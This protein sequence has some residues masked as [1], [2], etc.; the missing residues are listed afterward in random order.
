VWG[1]E[2]SNGSEFML[3][4]DPPSGWQCGFPREYKPR[5]GESV[6]DTLR[7]D[8]Y[9]EKLDPE[10]AARYCRFWETKLEVAAPIPVESTTENDGEK[11]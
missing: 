6:A 10:S 2:G 9:P 8:G 3:I 4:Y 7:R 5:P 1:S 11:S